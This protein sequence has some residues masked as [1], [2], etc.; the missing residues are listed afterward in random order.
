MSH[1]IGIGGGLGIMIGSMA[2]GLLIGIDA[3]REQKHAVQSVAPP[4]H[5]P[6]CAVRLLM[7]WGGT[8]DYRPQVWEFTDMTGQR[9]LLA[10]STHG[11]FSM[12]PANAP[13]PVPVTK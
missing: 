13:I 8:G 7:P 12:A 11:G 9:F 6:G 10:E 5:V 4:D 2:V 1:S 3:G